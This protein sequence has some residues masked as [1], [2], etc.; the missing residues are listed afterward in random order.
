MS[1]RSHRALR[2]R[3]TRFLGVSTAVGAPTL[4][5]MGLGGIFASGRGV[6]R[7]RF[8]FSL[9]TGFSLAVPVVQEEGSEMTRLRD[10]QLWSRFGGSDL[11]ALAAFW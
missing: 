10:C 9:G 7:T 8:V 11:E 3:E 1:Y 6:G 2:P 5:A 4:G